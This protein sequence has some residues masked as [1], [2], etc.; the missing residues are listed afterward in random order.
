VYNIPLRSLYSKDLDNM[1]MAGR[2]ASCS[3]V[4]FTSTRVMATCAVMGQA[5]GTAAALCARHEISPRELYQDKAKLKELQQTLLRDDQTIKHRKNEDPADLVS[6]ATVTASGHTSP[7]KPE[8][9]QTG[10]VRDMEDTHEHRWVAPMGAEGAWL[11]LRWEQ[12]QRIREVQLTFDSGFHRELTLTSSDGHNEHMIRAPQPETVRDYRLLV[13]GE[14][15]SWKEVAAMQG[16]HQRL[17][18]HTFEPVETTSLRIQ[19]DAT[20]GLN[21]A[22]LY[23]LRCYS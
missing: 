17:C 19:I 5:A 10:F 15:G 16:N 3:H 9:V 21:E 18:R 12:P 6:R 2:N 23:E 14:E 11:E 20:N 22:R 7:S 13:S 8:N 1:F 4:A